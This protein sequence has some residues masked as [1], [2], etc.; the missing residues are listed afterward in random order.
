M[1]GGKANG[2]LLWGGRANVTPAEVHA[3]IYDAYTVESISAPYQ[4]TLI[5]AAAAARLAFTS[6]LSASCSSV[7]I[8]GSQRQLLSSHLEGS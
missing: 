2:G 6:C 5:S 8:K 4:L 3:A 7:V 1:P